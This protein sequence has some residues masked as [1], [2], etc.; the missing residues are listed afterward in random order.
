MQTFRTTT[1]RALVVAVLALGGG[2]PVQPG[3]DALLT[4]DIEVEA[5]HLLAES[6]SPTTVLKVPHHGS[7]T[8]SSATFLD[9][10]RPAFGVISTRRTASRQATG[11]GVLPRYEERD[12]T[13]YRTDYHG[14][15]QVRVEDG[16]IR[17]QTARGNRGYT[18]APDGDGEGDVPAQ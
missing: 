2:L 17:V 6:L 3:M 12:I 11:R 1:R 7:H 9:A 8:S 5:E 4:G 13:I 18:L 15:I 14:G 16:V 10:T